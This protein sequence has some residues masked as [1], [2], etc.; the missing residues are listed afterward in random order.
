MMTRRATSLLALFS[1]LALLAFPFVH[2][3]LAQSPSPSSPATHSSDAYKAPAGDA[4]HG[5]NKVSAASSGSAV[6]SASSGLTRKQYA[7]QI[8]ATY[9]FR[10]GEEHPSTPGNAAIEGNDFIQPGAFPN[11]K[12]CAVCH[13]EAFRQWRQALH[14]NSFRTPFYRTSVNILLRTKGIEFT[15]HCDSCH[16]P[17]GV[18]TGALTQDSKVDR[19]FDSDGLT[20]LTCH[21][22]QKLQPTVGNGA[23]VMGVPSVMVDEQGNRIPGEVPYDEILKHPDRHSKAVMKS[24]YRT[25]EFCSAC[26]K[27]N[28]PDTLNDYKFLRAFTVYDEWQNSKFSKRNPLTFYTGDFTT[29][30]NCH[31]K[32]APSV[33]FDYGAK[34]GMFASHRWTAGNTAVPFY[35]GF[36]E[37]M[38][39]T[40]EFLKSGNYLNVDLFGIK[41]VNT[42]EF[43]APLGSVPFRLAPNDT[44]EA[45]VV[46]QNKNIGHSLI[47]EV[48]DLYE[49]WVEF[50]VSDAAGIKLY[51]SGYLKPDGSLDERA[52]SFTNRPVTEAGEFVDNH[53]V[54][55]I[56]SVAY[57]NTVQSGRSTLIR[58]AFQI[59]PDA[60]GPLTVTARVNYRHLRQSY[61]NNIFGK[62]HP[63]YPVIE[64][65]A[66]T[67]TLA[68][69]DNPASAEPDPQDN[70]DWMRWNNYG[71]ANLDQFQY[72]DAVDAFNEVIKLRPDYADAYTNVGLTE[73]AWEKYAS[74]RQSLHMSLSLA[75]D[76]ARALYYMG[77]I[78]RRA[79]DSDAEIADFQ[80]VV[81]QFPLSIDAHRELGKA[82]YRTDKLKEAVE[83]FEALQAIE[84]DDVTAH[85]NLSILYGRLGLDDQAAQ[86]SALFVNKKADPGAPTYSLGFLRMHPEISTE[87]VPWHMHTNL[88]EQAL[89]A[90]AA[91]HPEFSNSTDA[92]AADK[93]TGEQLAYPAPGEKSPSEKRSSIG[94][95]ASSKSGPTATQKTGGNR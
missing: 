61:L 52:H 39:K 93:A 6:P 70:P 14:S 30:Q 35:Y 47:P 15:R 51:H 21:A 18:L 33:R 87:S 27:A 8:R 13:A 5:A 48:R 20:C 67:R 71:I 56:H 46:V 58:Y 26:H 65:S 43:V 86:Q 53:K 63:A 29:C 7:D 17:I 2:R 88:D 83:Q 3:A 64:L 78:E 85:Y 60:H 57:D 11:A 40:V 4:A 41:K 59:P 72:A 36:D 76:N 68:L 95:S 66:R 82:Y 91:A 74:A 69:A 80:K 55:T 79:G 38:Q 25:P 44:V 28:L 22:V 24:F 62:D 19:Q 81:S 37:Q 16:N 75:N 34:N 50:T 1:A 90:L 31:M 54:W 73:I 89:A 42:G 92:P 12:Y 45:L 94:A 84:P 77:L 10:F 32:R 9:N 49:A 23:F